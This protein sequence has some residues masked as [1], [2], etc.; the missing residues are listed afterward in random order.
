MKTAE[1]LCTAYDRLTLNNYI[2]NQAWEN[3]LAH[4][5]QRSPATFDVWFAGVQ[6]DGYHDGVLCLS[7]RDEFVRDWVK[8]HFQP[9]LIEALADAQLSVVQVRWTI[10]PRIKKPVSQPPQN[11]TQRLSPKPHEQPGAL[12]LRNSIVAATTHKITSSPPFASAPS[13]LNP[14]NTFDNFVVGPS[15]QLA[16][17]AA[18]AACGGS[19][20]RYNPLFLCG[21]TGLGKTHLLHAIAQRIHEQ[22][23]T[24]R[25]V[26]GSADSFTNEYIAAL[27]DRRMDEFRARYHQCDALLIDDVQS[28]SGRT[29]TQEEFFNTFNV[30]H[31]CDKQIVVAADKYPQQLDRMEQRL[32]SR[33]TWGLVADVQTPELETRIAIVRKKA[34]LENVPLPDDVALLLAQTIQSNVR[35]LEGT[36][37]RLI[38]KSSVLNCR[39]DMQFAEQE[40]LPLVANTARVPTMQQIQQVVCG[41]FQVNPEDMLGKARHRSIAQARHVAMYLCRQRL[42]CSFPEIGRAFSNRDH[43]TVMSAV[44]KVH[45]QQ[46]RD[47]ELQAHLQAIEK[48]LSNG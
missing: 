24:H 29:Q 20:R 10:D 34:Q 11:D 47:P 2:D 8:E 39:L 26:Y 3:A 30:L 6:L 25:I 15:N 37:I 42:K 23:P 46:T 32:V 22:H 43:T 48:R 1:N 18:T 41:H 40:L 17:A 12:Q 9:A 21:S 31:A 33:F 13:G 44:K 14:N 16:F 19:G 38:A 28:L 45:S 27:S 5:R 35:E 4:L 36:L 7:A